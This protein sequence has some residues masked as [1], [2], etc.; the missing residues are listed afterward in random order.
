[1]A[2]QALLCLLLLLVGQSI[3]NA[4]A[5]RNINNTPFRTQSSGVQSA[6]IVDVDNP[7]DRT[8]V[9]KKVMERART[10]MQGQ[11]SALKQELAFFRRRGILKPNQELD[12]NDTVIIR[13]RGRLQLPTSNDRTRG[14]S[15]NL[16]FQ[17]T[18]T[19]DGAFTSAEATDIQN[20]INGIY[21]ELRDNILG[22]PGWSGQVVV[23]NL[24]PRLGKT[25]E[26]LG[27]L[28]VI[29]G[30]SVE[31]WFPDFRAFETR[32]LAMAQ[33][34]AQAFHA[35]QRIAFD[36]WEIGM[37]RAAAVALAIRLQAQLTGQTA[38]DPANGFYFT[39]YYDL[40]NQ[41]ALANSTFTP[42][43]KSDQPF[44][45]T[46]LA[47]M[48]V[49]RL[50]MSSTAWLKCYIENPNFFKQFNTGAANGLGTGGYYAAFATDNSTANS[51]TKLRQIAKNALPTV[52]GLDFDAWFEQQF[53]LNSSI[54][55]GNKLFVYAQ[56]TFPNNQQ[57][58]DSGAA[59]FVVYYRT[60]ST[61]DESDLSGTANLIYWDYNFINR[62]LLPSFEVVDVTNGF[63]TVAP[64]FN[65]IGGN[66]ADKMRIAID[67]PL[68]QQT[69]RVYLPAGHTGTANAPNDAQGVLVGANDG[70]VRV[71]FEGGSGA[72]TGNAVQGAF[73]LLGGNG[74]LPESLSRT[75][76]TFTP[77]GGQPITYRRNTYQRRDNA[78]RLGVFPVFVL[79][80]PGQVQ[81]LTHTFPAGAQLISL[82]LRPLSN[83]L[84]LALG[85]DPQKTLLAQYR[86]DL[87][88]ADKYLKYPSLPLYQ[89]GYGLWSNFSTPFTATAIRGER[90]DIQA[91]ISVQLPFGWTQIGSP[92]ETNLSLTNDLQFQYLGGEVLTLAE[93][94]NRNLVASGVIG[95]S[96]SAGYQDIRTT[97]AQGFPQNTLEAWKGYWIRV[98]VTEGITLTYANPNNR[99]AK[100]RST[101]LPTPAQSN[102]WTVPL[103][104]RDADGVETSALFGQAPNGADTFVPALHVAEPPPFTRTITPSI[105]FPHPDWEQGGDYLTDIRRSNTRSEW[106]LVLSTPKAE[107]NY[108]LTWKS[109]SHLPRGTRLTLVDKETGARLLLQTHSAYTFRTAKDSNTTRRIQIVAEPRGMGRLRITNLSAQAPL[110]TSGRAAQ[111][112]TILYDLSA[113]AETEIAIRQGGRLVR[114]LNNGRSVPSGTNQIVW[115]TRDDG[116]RTLPGGSYTIEV[117]AKNTDGEQTRAIV[118][119]LLTR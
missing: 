87:S 22:R 65:D 52:E 81:S 21:P 95:Y 33:V 96:P 69:V 39:P 103:T 117:T 86:Q 94:I 56:P 100:T 11:A 38:V 82:P 119:L 18:T 112:V 40:L 78:T 67:V 26:V 68:N 61:G 34:L 13:H 2:R 74:A 75:Q 63:G 41:P 1:M 111:S 37:A 24:D 70:A 85:A 6:L 118:P 48:L 31:I 105:R 57:G 35:K 54:T 91:Y 106:N 42:P 29:N 49:P 72:I 25:D 15:D 88:G 45:P 9:Q 36:A 16:T 107:H 27:A 66:P 108:T 104:L 53:V 32:F 114:R 51:V 30:N 28:L 102:I 7:N 98:L 90:T 99:S 20:L 71:T 19:G 93:A 92:Y 58:S 80:A 44:N 3:L 97:T 83:D 47:G 62:L 17:I 64:F 73:G 89:P 12:F 109:L 110:A 115:D 23:K 55:P 60:T 8:E 43:T 46:T 5:Y 77:T 116:G 113:S 79:F 76:I 14:P 84:A 101:N 59:L 10:R 50:Q 4:Q